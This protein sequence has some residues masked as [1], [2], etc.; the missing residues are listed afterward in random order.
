MR[1]KVCGEKDLSRTLRL[2]LRTTMDGTNIR[3]AACKRNVWKYTV[4]YGSPNDSTNDQSTYTLIQV[5]ADIVSCDFS[6]IN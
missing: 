4:V 5:L 2:N 6:F 1:S 3:S